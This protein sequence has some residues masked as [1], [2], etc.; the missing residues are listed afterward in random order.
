MH[1]TLNVHVCKPHTR[2]INGGR[3]QRRR[4]IK[5]GTEQPQSGQT[6]VNEAL[7]ETPFVIVYPI[8]TT[9]ALDVLLSSLASLNTANQTYCIWCQPVW[10]DPCIV[11]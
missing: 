3:E 5:T 4:M 10:C 7:P 8:N 1:Y 6:I 9:S 11:F 2:E